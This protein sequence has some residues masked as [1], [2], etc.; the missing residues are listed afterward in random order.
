MAQNVATKCTYN[1][2]GERVFV[3]FNGTCSEKTIK[4]NIEG[5]RV[6]CNQQKC[7]CRKYYDRGFQGDPPA[8][9]CMESALFRDWKYGAGM[10]QTGKRARTPVHI[11]DVSEGKIAILTTRFPGDKEEDRKIIGFFKIRDVTN[12]RD[13]E[14]RLIAHRD[15][16]VRPPLEEAKELY[17]WDYYCTQG[18]TKWG[19]LLF[20]YLDDKTVLRILID[21]GDTV[22]DEE[23]KIKIKKPI[24][25]DFKGIHP[26]PPSGPRIK[27]AND[28]SKRNISF[29]LEI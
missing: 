3:G 4:R 13:E 24:E 26:P 8:A 25:I 2:G 21:I 18:G 11:S 20:R 1:D 6:W 12:K 10:Y 9:P 29:H 15:L 28:R 16:R 27:S 14:T 17:F 22:R 23:A 7:G 5:G 19:T